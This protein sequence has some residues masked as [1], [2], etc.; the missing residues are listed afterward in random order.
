[1]KHVSLTLFGLLCA[2]MLS[3][4]NPPTVVCINGM[5]VNLMPNGETIIWTSDVLQYA[6][7]DET[8]FTFL[9][10]GMRIE[11]TGS[12]FPLD[13]V[14]NAQA[15]ITFTC[16][17]L[18]ENNVELWARDAEGNT[19]LCLTQVI[20]NDNGN[21][22][23]ANPIDSIPPSVVTSDYTAANVNASGTIAMEA[24]QLV[25]FAWDNATPGFL[26]AY[27]L[28]IEGTGSGFPID[29]AGNPQNILNFDCEALGVHVVEVWARDQS[30]NANFVLT[31]LEITDVDDVCSSNPIS[32]GTNEQNTVQ[33]L[34]C[35]P[36][37]AGR[38]A[39]LK[40]SGLSLQ[41]SWQIRIS[42]LAG[43]ML[44]QERGNGNTFELAGKISNPGV[45]FLRV[46]DNAGKEYAGKLLLLS[47]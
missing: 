16:Q 13:A 46:T 14:G 7:D 43:R 12:G 26:L 9:E 37:P 40:F 10:F 33:M 41:S 2:F 11:G 22:C 8:A 39:Q 18:G 6:E 35:V 15:S 45:Y 25:E 29:A 32:T 30:G 36:N 31:T 1:M 34:G 3:A 4:S 19:S 42:D 21:Y 27:A 20:I 24:L 17:Q 5:L 23:P 47:E 44:V 38:S 28:R